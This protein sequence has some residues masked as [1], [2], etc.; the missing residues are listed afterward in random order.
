MVFEFRDIAS[1]LGQTAADED[2]K[3]VITGFS[4]DTRT[5]KPGMMFIAIPGENFDGSNYI[6]EAFKKGAIGAITEKN[7]NGKGIIVVNDVIKALG[8]L[9]VSHR[10]KSGIPLV[11]VTGSTGKTSTRNFIFS[12]LSEKYK[13]HGTKGNL[14]NHIGM[15][16][17]ILKIKKS[18][19]ISVL[20]MG[21]SGFG[22]IDYLASIAKPDTGVITNIGMSHIG[23]LGSM[24]N[25]CIAKS[26]MIAHIKEGGNLFVNGDDEFLIRLKSNRSKQVTTFGKNINSDIRFRNEKVNKQGCYTFE[27]DGEKFA[28]RV[29]GYHNIYNA[30]AAIA[31][32]KEY[33]LTYSDIRSGLMKF[34]NEKFRLDISKTSGLTIIN[35][36]YNASPDSMKSSLSILGDFKGRKIA[37]LGD[38]LEMGDFSEQAHLEIGRAVPGNAEFLICCGNEAVNIAKGANEAGMPFSSINQFENSDMAGPFLAE[39]VKKG[40][41]ILIKGSRGMKMENVIKYIET[42]G[43]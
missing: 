2:K 41:V 3:L 26:E 5:I 24:E 8:T 17:T 39:L 25:I 20:E 19:D 35:D 36:A 42:G 27:V 10:D 32:G 4:T 11:A 38:M 16:M 22:E 31:V 9:A 7:I 1:A 13:V 12:V 23:K 43:K 33:G 28:L 37:V 18:H 14:N 29:R 15:P 6:E 30:M 21:M 34:K 40:D